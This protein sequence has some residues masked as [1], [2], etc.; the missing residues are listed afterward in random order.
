M[1]VDRESAGVRIEMADGRVYVPVLV[2]GQGPY[3]LLLDTGAIGCNLSCEVAERLQLA[4]DDAGTAC[5]RTLAIGC[6]EWQDI[7]FGVADNSSIA[8]MLGRR[9]D[10]LLGN[11]F[12]WHVRDEFVVT[13]DYPRGTISFARGGADSERDAN[14]GEHPQRQASRAGIEIENYY[15]VVPTHLDGQGPYRFLL[16]TGSSECI[17]SPEVAAALGLRHGEPCTAH[18]IVDAVE[19]YRS[20]VSE[21]A[22]GAARRDGI[23]VVVIDCSRES[24][25]V[26]GR[27]DGVIGSSFLSAFAVTL[28]YRE[29]TLTLTA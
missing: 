11:G 16:D 24:G 8:R 5:L 1:S 22:V 4:V 13:I 14:G 12:I 15:T 25:Y 7:R 19:G 9:I 17:V 21:L 23:D 18:G 26:H 10:G 20:S 29:R 6:A 2:N 3:S 28:N 27:L